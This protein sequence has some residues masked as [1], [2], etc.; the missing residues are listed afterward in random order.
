MRE[1]LYFIDFMELGIMVI[2][3]DIVKLFEDNK[4]LFLVLVF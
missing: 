2:F 4:F 1:I 3:Y